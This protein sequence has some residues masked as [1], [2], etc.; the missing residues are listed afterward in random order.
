VFATVTEESAAAFRAIT[1]VERFERDPPGII[2]AGVSEQTNLPVGTRWEPAEGLASAE[3]QRTGRSAR[4]GAD[5]DWSS[6]G[7]P[8]A[9]EVRRLGIISQ[10]SCPIIVEGSLWGVITVNA[11]EE[12]PP[13]TEERLEKFTELVATAIANAESKSELAASRRRIV[14]ASDE[15]RRRIERDLHDGTQQRLVSLGLALR[16]AESSLPPDQD[17]VRARLANVADGPGDALEDLQ[18]ISRGIHP[19]I[20]SRGVSLRRCERSRTVLR[21]P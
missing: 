11:R 14:A 18:E 1:C 6:R 4:L 3:V 21:F 10:V 2:L 8:A 20:L 16:A 5:Y 12:L 7:G 19:A 17:D 13:D 15:S 9:K